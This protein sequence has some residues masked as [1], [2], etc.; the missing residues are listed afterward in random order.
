MACSAEAK[1][2]RNSGSTWLTASHRLTDWFAISQRV[3]YGFSDSSC[4]SN[5]YDY[6]ESYGSLPDRTYFHKSFRCHYRFCCCNS[7][8]IQCKRWETYW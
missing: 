7:N 1:Q 5:H 2:G 8:H 6:S 4:Y 3:A